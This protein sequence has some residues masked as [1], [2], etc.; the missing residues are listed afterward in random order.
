LPG[1]ILGLNEDG[2]FGAQL[3]GTVYFP[4]DLL[5]TEAPASI[6]IDGD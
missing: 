6:K 3:A 4:I 5:N 1:F 2:S